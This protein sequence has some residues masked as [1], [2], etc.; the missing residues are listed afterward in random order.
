V[1]TWKHARWGENAT[2][3]EHFTFISRTSKCAALACVE[4]DVGEFYNHP[5]KLMLAAITLIENPD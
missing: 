3:V 2:K 1:I 4:I 5:S